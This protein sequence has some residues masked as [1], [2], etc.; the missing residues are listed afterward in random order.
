MAALVVGYQVSRPSEKERACEQH[1]AAAT[2]SQAQGD[3]AAARSQSAL[4]VLAC[5]GPS[6]ARALAVQAAAEQA[7]QAQASRAAAQA[8]CERGYRRVTSQLGENR[9]RSARSALDQLDASCLEAAAGRTERLKLDAAFSLAE[10]TEALVRQKLG[11]GDLRA[12]RAALDQL[13]AQ[14]REHPDLNSLRQD[15][16]AATAAQEVAAANAAAG[17]AALSALAIQPAAPT[18]LPTSRPPAVAS[19]ST[20]A[21][22]AAR[23]QTE[24]ARTFLR[25]AE[26]AMQQ[27]QFDK[28][29]TLV[30]SAERI[31]PSNVQAAALARR[32]RERELEYAR[33][34]MIIR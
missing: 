2:Q 3:R 9:L 7:L 24:L 16:K 18:V 32:I 20:P 15:I 10:S 22:T 12:A 28:A 6:Q 8:T 14:N 25:D 17:A 27:L 23:P 21:T 19:T 29:K 11:E 1:L 26:A 13:A 4:A 30:E 5:A 33:K 31:D 34:E